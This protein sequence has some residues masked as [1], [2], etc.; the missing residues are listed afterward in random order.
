MITTMKLKLLFPPFVFCLVF[1]CGSRST[2]EKA[3][4][5]FVQTDKQGV[6]TD[7]Q[8][9]VIEMGEPVMITVGDSIRILKDAFE[10]KRRKDLDF[11]NTHVERYSS[12]LQKEGFSAMRKFYQNRV[13]KYQ[14]MADSLSRLKPVLP[15]SYADADPEKVLAQEVTCKFSIMAPFIK[16]RQEITETFILNADGSKCYRFKP[17][18][19][20]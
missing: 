8:F 4:A 1:G 5:D 16:A 12:S 13:D 19:G 18:K 17:G 11:A 20:E 10:K 6:W 14:K 2:S 3:I 9:E 7:L 15:V